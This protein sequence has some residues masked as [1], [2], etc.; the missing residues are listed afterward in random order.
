MTT[1]I[2][3][4]SYSSGKSYERFKQELLAW[5]EITEL[6]KNKQGIAVALSLPEDDENKIKDKVFDQISLDELK[7]EDGLYTLIAF[8]D[9]HLGKDDLADSIEKFEDFDDFKRKEGQTIHEFIAMFDSKYRKIEKKDMSLPSE[10]LAFKLMKKANIT[11]EE[12]LLVLTG[13]N[14]DN[15]RFLYEEAKSSLKKFKGDD[16]HPRGNENVSIKLEPAYLAEHEDVLLAA[17]Y[18]KN[19]APYDR[20]RKEGNYM[21]GYEKEPSTSQ[22]N[23]NPKN[24]GRRMNPLGKDGRALTCKACGSFRHMLPECPDS[25]ENMGK[26]NNDDEV[27][28]LETKYN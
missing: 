8:L 17:G 11:K 27:L 13:M 18:V 20:R 22:R 21:Y 14:F 2:N 16:V 19:N 28:V 4:P 15:K 25:W 10:I 23:F 24:T 1:R 12:K 9:K 5:R 7:A 26:I 3:P 6:S